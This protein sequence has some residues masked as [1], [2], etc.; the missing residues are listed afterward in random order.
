MEVS[1]RPE[2]RAKDL[3]RHD[4]FVFAFLDDV[5]IVILRHPKNKSLGFVEIIWVRL[6]NR[7]RATR[8]IVLSEAKDL[9]GHTQ[10]ADCRCLGN[11]GAEISALILRHP[12]NKNLGFVEIVWVRLCNLTSRPILSETTTAPIG[13][14]VGSISYCRHTVTACHLFAVFPLSLARA[15]SGKA[16]AILNSRLMRNTDGICEK[17]LVRVTL[18]SS[19]WALRGAANILFIFGTPSHALPKRAG[20]RFW[21]LSAIA[22]LLLALWGCQK[23]SVGPQTNVPHRGVFAGAHRALANGFELNDGQWD[24]RVKFRAGSSRNLFLT[25][26]GFVI[27][28]SRPAHSDSAKLSPPPLKQ[29][30]PSKITKSFVGLE[31]IDAN[32]HPKISGEKLLPGKSNYF[33]GNDP[34]K[35]KRNVPHYAVVR[36][37]DLYPGIDLI[38]HENATGATEYDL[39][40]A[41]GADPTRIQLG[42]RGAR[43][44]KLDS[45]GELV[46]DTANGSVIGHA[47]VLYQHIDGVRKSIAGKYVLNDTYEVGFKVGAYDHSKPLI[48]DPTVLPTYSTFLGGSGTDTGTGIAVDSNGS[49]YITGNT[50][51]ADFPTQGAY[52]GLSTMPM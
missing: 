43:S 13:R 2:R 19:N 41:P 17:A 5:F 34:T 48:I 39:L 38:V 21:Q 6:C 30:Q 46:L 11:S 31:F 8:A 20:R 52:Q 40:T 29:K 12:K 23:S 51:S 9:D 32:S 33:I 7:P 44:A 25:D 28:L 4:G 22:I 37:S 10:N 24:S 18:R 15:V 42:I 14:R 45:S 50:T 26:S 1:G 49:V 35:W 47:P 3:N 27:A 16:G 36:Y